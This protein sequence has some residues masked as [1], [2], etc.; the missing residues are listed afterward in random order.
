M[1]VLLPF[2]C[3]TSRHFESRIRSDHLLTS[4][5]PLSHAVDE[6]FKLLCDYAALNPDS[7]MEG[8]VITVAS[9]HMRVKVACSGRHSFAIL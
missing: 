4:P 9:V 5:S 6:I 8:E 2:A 7:E 1:R 3:H